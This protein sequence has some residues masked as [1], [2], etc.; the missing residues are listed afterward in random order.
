MILVLLICAYAFHSGLFAQPT[1]S[2]LSTSTGSITPAD[3]VFFFQVLDMAS[4]EE[5]Q[6]DY[7]MNSQ[8]HFYFMTLSAN[9]VTFYL[10]TW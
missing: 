4:F 6:K 9:E 1:V 3:F 10:A 7:S 5:R 8:K 2:Y